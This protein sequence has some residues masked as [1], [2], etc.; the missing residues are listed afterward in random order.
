[1]TLYGWDTSHYDGIITLGAAR[2]ARAEGIVFATA[3]IGE[4]RNYDDPAD[5][6]NLRNLRDAGIPLLAGYYVPRSG[7]PVAAQVDNL[8]RLADRDEPWWRDFP[9]WGWQVDLERWQYD[10][11]PAEVGIEFGYQ[12]QDRTD[13]IALMYASRGQYGNQLTAWDGALWNADYPSA[14][15][16]PFK[17]LYPGDDYRH[18]WNPYSGKTP[19]LLQYASSATIGGMSTC[20]AN[21]FRGSFPE[22]VALWT[23]RKHSD[24]KWLAKDA[25]SGRIWLC[26]G[27]TRRELADDKEVEHLRYLHTVGALDLWTGRCPEAPDS[28][29]ENV[30][31]VMGIPIVG[32]AEITDA[33]ADSIADKIAASMGAKLGDMM[34]AVVRDELDHTGLSR[35]A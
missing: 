7:V 30:S 3:K 35:N 2:A 15:Q 33:E 14:R 13:R 18:G 27:I 11:V 24:M 10:P 6:T 16:A 23:G 20:D 4:G 5:S 25:G 28:I 34:R 1:M 17:D 31:D 12:V 21:A 19:D 26:D 8:I 22:L 32:D 9:G 29:W